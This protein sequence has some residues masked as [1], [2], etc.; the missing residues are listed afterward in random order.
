MGPTVEVPVSDRTYDS[1]EA[2]QSI[3]PAL[4]AALPDGA[5][6]EFA[7][8]YSAKAG[9]AGVA[10]FAEDLKLA[11]S[12]RRERFSNVEPRRA[13]FFERYILKPAVQP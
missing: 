4:I 10:R 1:D 8:L 2:L 13:K 11:V 12:D 7:E 3:A 5:K 9:P 6:P